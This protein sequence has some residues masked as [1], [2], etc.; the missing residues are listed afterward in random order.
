[1]LAAI[2][3]Q[4]DTNDCATAGMVA[5]QNWIDE[6]PLETHQ[7]LVPNCAPYEPGNFYRREMPVILEALALTQQVIQ[8]IIVDGYVD[9]EI[10]QPGLGRHLHDELDGNMVVIGVAKSR[11]HDSQY[12]EEIYRGESQKPLFV[13]AAG[14]PNREAGA[15]VQQMAGE[16][17]MPKLLKLADSIARGSH[18][19]TK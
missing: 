9:F 12:A 8:T 15:C 16:F 10:D 6:N 2:D 3:V 11:F 7:H 13:T 17:R 18:Q 5:F 19:P 1:M 4:Y 14:I